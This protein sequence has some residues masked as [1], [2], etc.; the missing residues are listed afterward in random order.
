MGDPSHVA[1]ACVAP[2][3]ARR[4]RLARERLARPSAAPGRLVDEVQ[5]AGGAVVFR[6]R[7]LGHPPED[8]WRRQVQGRRAVSAR[9]TMLE[10]HRRGTRQAA[11]AGAVHVLGAAPEG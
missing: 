7:A 8:E 9:A 5:R 4:D 3:S 2:A 1:P 11:H 10:R 6:N